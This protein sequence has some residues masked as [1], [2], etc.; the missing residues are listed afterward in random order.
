MIKVFKSSDSKQV[1]I[2]GVAFGA[3]ED[4]QYT[5]D[6]DL[7]T[8][9]RINTKVVEVNKASYTLFSD[10]DGQ[11]FAD[12][13]AFEAHLTSLLV[14]ETLVTTAELP[15]VQD[16]ASAYDIWIAEGNSGT[17]QD[18][19]DSLEGPQGEQGQ[20]GSDSTVP[21]PQG[22]QG[23]AGE[24]FISYVR[25]SNTNASTNI[26]TSTSAAF[27][28]DVPLFGN[29]E[30]S[31]NESD[32]TVAGNTIIFNFTGYVEGYASVHVFSAGQRNAV[33][34][35]RKIN[36]SPQGPIASTG[37]IRASSGHSEASFYLPIAMKVTQGQVLSIGSRRE[38][39]NGSTTRL[40]SA[41]TSEIYL[42]RIR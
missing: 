16:G 17:E 2:E 21:G 8:I 19:L 6:G 35:R 18:F 29:L 11:A 25:Y 37:Y 27:L 23:P 24:P 39:T 40:T 15:Q 34:L 31:E 36:T 26:N 30:D 10:G 28:A 9:D 14:I 20:P 42:K 5:R 41:G 33:Q 32:Y 12:A 4:F 7:F 1:Y 22:P 38:G 3:A 13:D